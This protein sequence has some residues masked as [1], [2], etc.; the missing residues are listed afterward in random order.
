MSLRLTEQT[1]E[2]EIKEYL[3]FNVFT[4]DIINF[5]LEKGYD[6]NINDTD[7]DTA[8][9]IAS[10]TENEEL[11][12]TIIDAGA[13]V[14]IQNKDGNTALMIASIYSNAET[15]D[16]IKMLIN[17][18]TDV[19]IQ[20]KDGNTALMLACLHSNEMSY[21]ETVKYLI[22]VGADVNIQNKDGNT[23]LIFASKYGKSI[24]IDEE[25]LYENILNLLNAG[26][27]VNIQNKDGN[28]ALMLASLY[29]DDTSHEEIVLQ[30]A[31]KVMDMDTGINIQ[32]KD[33]NTALMLACLHSNDT[34]NKDTV[35]YLI[36]ARADLDIQ[37]E[38]GNTAL[39]LA[40]LHS[41]DTSSDVTVKFLIENEAD[42]N[43]KNKDGKTAFDIMKSVNPRSQ[44]L[45]LLKPDLQIHEIPE[46]VLP[47]LQQKIKVNI[48]KI[49]SFYD[50]IMLSDEDIHIETFIQED[51]NNI[52][53]V[54][55]KNNYFFT[56]RD[57]IMTQKND[58][59]IYPCIQPDT[60]R[61]ENIIRTKPLYDLK[62]IGFVA[63]FPCVMDK[64]FENPENQLFALINTNEKYP[65]FVS[66][67]VLNR[68]GSYV[69]GLHCQSGQESRISYLIIAEPSSE[70]NPDTVQ[71]GGVRTLKDIRKFENMKKKKHTRKHKNMKKN[72][73]KHKSI[74]KNTRKHKS[75]KKYTR[76]HKN[77]T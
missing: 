56:N 3:K 10:K 12:R 31:D 41:N 32:N 58:A 75:I 2:S 69:S 77:K 45:E 22:D 50:P 14:N 53:I 60:M 4:I 46:E 68:G 49:V 76:K 5:I 30:L 67:N 17:A 47:L 65:S 74:K 35:Q 48:N 70:D 40:C 19:N 73:R 55:N 66:D 62:K 39:M 11:L 27:D 61:D 28:T 34:S 24:Y 42:V 57:T 15:E 63:G 71:M 6:I 20:N 23:A 43:I 44:L 25:I 1:T 16:I 7:G 51:K 54:Y 37:N 9:V 72:T 26:A 36:N 8:L 33:G 13:D 59:T 38:D 18:G 64:F 29:S 52:V 21:E